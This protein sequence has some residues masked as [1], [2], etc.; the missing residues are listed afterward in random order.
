M[1][2]QLA[3]ELGD[4]L[5][6][7]AKTAEAGID[8][9]IEDV[10]LVLV[11]LVNHEADHLFTLLGHHA[12]AVALTQ[13]AQEIFFG[14]GILKALLLRLQDLRHVPADH[15]AD[16]DTNLFLFRAVR[17]HDQPPLLPLH[18]RGTPSVDAPRRDRYAPGS[19][20]TSSNVAEG[21]FES[22]SGRRTVAP[23]SLTRPNL[24]NAPV[25]A[26]GQWGT[27]FEKRGNP[28]P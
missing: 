17:T 5:R 22:R 16:M 6:A 15:P 23:S 11:Q 1:T 13:A 12:D 27:A 19:G 8:G 24:N 3:N 26:Q 28:S 20:G 2:G 10:Q 18:A 25:P 9:E 14:P 4:H 7:D 21:L